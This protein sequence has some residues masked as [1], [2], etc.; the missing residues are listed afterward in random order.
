MNILEVFH[1]SMYLRKPWVASV[2]FM[3]FLEYSYRVSM[4]SQHLDRV[5]QALPRGSS[6]CRQLRVLE[7]ET[8]KEDYKWDVLQHQGL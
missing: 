7:L 4:Y 8:P 5:F 6:N 3:N 1:Q 2:S